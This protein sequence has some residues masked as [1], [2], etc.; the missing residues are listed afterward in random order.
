M[1]IKMRTWT[2]VLLVCTIMS[3]LCTNVHSA[4]KK[5]EKKADD[6]QQR[7]DEVKQLDRL[8]LNILINNKP[9]K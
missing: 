1:R 5:V 2:R 9:L 3:L 4:E 6:V 7:I 8:E